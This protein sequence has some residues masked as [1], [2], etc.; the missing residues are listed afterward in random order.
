MG[1][2]VVASCELVRSLTVCLS[3]DHARAGGQSPFIGS[4]RPNM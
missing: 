2:K 4:G 1:V 3:V